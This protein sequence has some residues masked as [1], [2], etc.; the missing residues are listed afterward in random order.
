MRG[1]RRP[2]GAL[3]REVLVCLWAAGR[4]LA[5]TEVQESLGDGLA[6]TT[7]MTI[8]SRLDA[9]GL[10][11]RLPSPGRPHHYEPTLSEEELTARR[12]VELLGATGDRV[13]VLSRFLGSL[14][15]DDR[16]ALRNELRRQPRP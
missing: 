3:E 7:V 10:A 9:K 4:P 16:D 2:K 8:L 13:A 1:Q 12:M 11:R 15:D 14:R 6:Y 5:V